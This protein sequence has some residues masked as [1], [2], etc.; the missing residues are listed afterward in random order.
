MR[1]LFKPFIDFLAV[2]SGA[3]SFAGNS[4]LGNSLLNKM[5]LHALRVRT[6]AAFAGYRR[7]FLKRFL[8]PGKQEEYLEHGYICDRDFLSPDDFAALR[9]EVVESEWPLREMRQ[10]GTVTRRVFLDQAELEARHP[11]L[12][13]FLNNRDL[14][15]RIRYVAGVGGAPV[16]SIQAVLSEANNVDDPQM[17][18]HSDTFHSNAK[19]W[20]FLEDVG[21]EDGPFAYV[22]GSHK[23]TGKRLAWEK[24]KSLTARHDPVV[25]HA[26]GSL[27]ATEEDLQEMGLPTPT[28]ISVPANTLV[29]ADTFGFHRRSSAPHATCRVEIYAVLRRN[30]FLPWTG[31]DP[32]SIPWLRRRQGEL[33]LRVLSALRRLGLAKMPWRLVGRG[34]IKDPVLTAR[35]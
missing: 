14:L 35:N 4:V 31:L 13:A 34:R 15:S 8:S 25:Y 33:T 7:F 11:T 29:V 19:A 6:A 18:V 10:G 27:R 32:F 1:F 17:V 16:F 30:P 22:A 3:K 23:A 12:A 26:R 2:F 20:F 9:K 24:K 21:D 5:G 28:A